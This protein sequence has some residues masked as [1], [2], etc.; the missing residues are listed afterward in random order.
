MSRSIT[1]APCGSTPADNVN[2]LT[3]FKRYAQDLIRKY[4]DSH[5]INGY[6][7]E[8]SNRM[9]RSIYK[10]TWSRKKL[11]LS[12]LYTLKSSDNDVYNVIERMIII[13]MLGPGQHRDI[14]QYNVLADLLGA[15]RCDE[16]YKRRRNNKKKRRTRRRVQVDGCSSYS[17]TDSEVEEQPKTHKRKLQP[18]D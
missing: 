3:F 6:T 2:R 18:N 13:S 4:G 8:Y 17:E 10:V 5:H 15:L 14:D 1:A 12:R 9:T 11:T 16:V 7:F